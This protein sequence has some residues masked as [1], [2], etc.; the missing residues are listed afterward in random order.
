MAKPDEVFRY[1]GQ[2]SVYT[3]LFK[4]LEKQEYFTQY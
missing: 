1:D 3:I 4:K 2:K